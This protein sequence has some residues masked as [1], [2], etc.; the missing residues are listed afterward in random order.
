MS[1]NMVSKILKIRDESVKKIIEEGRIEVIMI[2]KRIKIPMISLKKF[3]DENAR[4]IKIEEKEEYL[5]N[6]KGYLN[7]K[8]DSII[9][10]HIRR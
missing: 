10:K 1:V 8:V 2:G 9:K 7:T 6:T 3:I 4:I 5:T